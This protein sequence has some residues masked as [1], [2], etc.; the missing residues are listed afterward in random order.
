MTLPLIIKT[1]P[2]PW[3]YANKFDRGAGAPERGA[4]IVSVTIEVSVGVVGVGC[5]NKQKTD[6]IDEEFVTA[7]PVPQVVDLVLA[8]A[9]AVRSLIVRN[10]SLQ[11]TS[12]ARLLSIVCFAFDPPADDRRAPPLSQP[13]PH[14]EW[15]RFYG[16]RGATPLE[17]LRVQTFNTLEHPTVLR[18]VDGTG[19]RIIPGDQ[20]SRALFVSGRYE[21]NTLCVLRRF[22]RPGD[23]CFDVGANAG[24]ISLAASQWVAPSGHVYSFEPSEREFARLLDNLDLNA[25]SAVTPVRAALC[26]SSGRVPLRVAVSSHGGLNTLGNR[27]AYDNVDVVGVETVEALTIDE[28][29]SRNGIERVAVI[30]LDV[31]GAEGAALLGGRRVLREHRP[32]LI[33]EVFAQALAANAWT[34]DNLQ[35]LL[36]EAGYRLFSIDDATAALT[37]VEELNDIGER[38]VAALPEERNSPFELGNTIAGR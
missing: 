9:G 38:N 21:P 3:A 32:A 23:V 17:K 19:I 6:F 29:V 36:R 2:E 33:V 16:T 28:F 31:E 4:V 20:L 34:V 22:L 35:R 18:W 10:A 1:P 13:E 11:G 8:D 30:K 12:E 37:P 14:P 25:N 15:E 24:V 27:F 7:R 26:D 5:L